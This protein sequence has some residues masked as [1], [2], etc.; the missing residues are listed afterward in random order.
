MNENPIWSWDERARIRLIELEL[1]SQFRGCLFVKSLFFIPYSTVIHY[2]WHMVMAMNHSLWIVSYDAPMTSYMMK[3][4]WWKRNS[5]IRKPAE[6][7]SLWF[8]SS[9]GAGQKFQNTHRLEW[10]LGKVERDLG[11]KSW[12][13]VRP[14]SPWSDLSKFHK[15]KLIRIKNE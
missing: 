5:R 13:L 12:W 8:W 4:A 1:S 14:R 10:E 7:R 3:K 9:M 11:V 15:R 6:G 2:Q